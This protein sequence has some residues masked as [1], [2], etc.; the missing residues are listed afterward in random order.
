MTSGEFHSLKSGDIIITNSPGN[1]YD[2]IRLRVQTRDEIHSYIV[3]CKPIDPTPNLHWQGSNGLW[4]VTEPTLYSKIER[5]ILD[6]PKT[7]LALLDLE[8]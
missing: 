3:Y 2:G 6:Q 7:R 1:P 8:D 4:S 5:Q